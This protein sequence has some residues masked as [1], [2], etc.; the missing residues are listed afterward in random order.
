MQNVVRIPT[1]KLTEKRRK[2]AEARNYIAPV[3]LHSVLEPTQTQV[4]TFKA[5][6]DMKSYRAML[7]S[8]NKQ[9]EYRYRTIR[10]EHSMW[11]IVVWRMH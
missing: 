8:I 11:G 4:I 7:Y 9:G 5:E 10:D 6:K 3:D 1:N 2:R